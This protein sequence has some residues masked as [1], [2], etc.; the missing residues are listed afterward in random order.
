LSARGAIVV[1]VSIAA[2]C[3]RAPEET[4]APR[5]AE[6]SAP[7]SV[8]AGARE[9]LVRC[10]E[11]CDRARDELAALYR[12]CVADPTS[13]PHLVATG[14]FVGVGCCEEAR[15]S[16]GDACGVEGLEACASRWLAECGAEA[17][18]P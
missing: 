18:T 15:T 6:P 8:H 4:R 11:A 17:R 12:G 1:L 7:I 13:S 16:Y 3:G 14:A 5:R 2:G 9:V 10:A